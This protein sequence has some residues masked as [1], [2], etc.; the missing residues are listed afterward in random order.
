MEELVNGKVG[1]DGPKERTYTL[2]L[3]DQVNLDSVRG[4]LQKKRYKGLVSGLS[5][6]R[7]YLEKPNVEV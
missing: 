2:A 3:K 1:G 5:S 6:I 4:L 7:E